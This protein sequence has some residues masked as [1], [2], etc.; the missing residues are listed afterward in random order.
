MQ[1][2]PPAADVAGPFIDGVTGDLQYPIGRRVAREAGRSDAARLQLKLTGDRLNAPAGSVKNR[3][4]G[5]SDYHTGVFRAS[6]FPLPA[7]GSNGNLGHIAYR[8][9]AYAQVDMALSKRFAIRERL[10]AKLSF[11]AF[12][13]FN[14]V[15]IENPLIDWNNINFGRST[16]SLT[17]RQYQIGLRLQF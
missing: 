5:R 2:I 14:R 8:C 6:D 3:G 4:W 15:N 10:S 17:P 13:A 7:P 12:N 9:P 1:Q 16:P 11:D